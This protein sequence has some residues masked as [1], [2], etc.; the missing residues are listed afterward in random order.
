[1]T[2][3]RQPLVVLDATLRVRSA[4][5]A[6]YTLFDVTPEKTEERR[7]GEMGR[8]GLEIPD[9]RR[10]EEVLAK[11]QPL[12]DVEITFGTSE[13]QR[14]MLLNARRLERNGGRE[15]L[16]LLA[17]E[18]ITERKRADA[19]QTMLIAE[20]NHRVKNVLPPFKPL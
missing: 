10:L 16:I 8:E 19:H 13:R 14:T 6:F 9:L 15:E 2:T 20:L 18:E 11:N 17:I 5:R 7:L 4:N 1:V 3:V 12:N